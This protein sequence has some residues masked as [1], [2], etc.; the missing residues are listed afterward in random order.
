MYSANAPKKW[1]C[2]H[3]DRIDCC[4]V[5]R[6][7][8]CPT[9]EAQKKLDWQQ[10]WQV[11]LQHGI[12]VECCPLH[13]GCQPSWSWLAKSSSRSYPSRMHLVLQVWWSK[14]SKCLN[15][16]KRLKHGK[17]YGNSQAIVAWNCF[18]WHFLLMSSGS[19]S[20][21]LMRALMLSWRLGGTAAELHSRLLFAPSSFI[22]H[23]FL[24]AALYHNLWLLV[25]KQVGSFPYVKWLILIEGRECG[26]TSNGSWTPV[27]ASCDLKRAKCTG[28]ISLVLFLSAF[29]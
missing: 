10:M 7:G 2:I 25:A 24:L 29:A 26:L 11:H 17:I 22:L 5:F 15:A 4:Q 20:N 19:G 23:I 16:S 21:L 27:E 6:N 3:I 12:M 14:G 8:G 28:T 18:Y 1:F 9:K 13:R